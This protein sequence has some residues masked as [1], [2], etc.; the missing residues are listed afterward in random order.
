MGH[1]NASMGA[2]AD[3]L[4]LIVET[5]SKFYAAAGLAIAAVIAET[6]LQHGDQTVARCQSLVVGA[7]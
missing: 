7:L 4:A 3:P 6:Q 1:Q 2:D 5:A